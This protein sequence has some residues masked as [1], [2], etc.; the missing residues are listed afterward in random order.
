MIN[1]IETRLLLNKTQESE[2]DSCVV[3]WSK[4]YRQV[5]KLYNNQKLSEIDIYHKIMGLNLL[6]SYQVKSIINKVKSEHGIYWYKNIMNFI[7]LEV[8][9]SLSIQ[10]NPFEPKL[11]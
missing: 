3:L 11:A 6:T 10:I 5:W 2:I 9:K 4:I 1:T 7:N 8:D